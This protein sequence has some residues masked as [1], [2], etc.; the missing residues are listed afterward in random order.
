[1]ISHKMPDYKLSVCNNAGYGQSQELTV[2][3]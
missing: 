3:Y 2:K 1:M